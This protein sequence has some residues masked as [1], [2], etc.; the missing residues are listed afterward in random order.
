M[1][2][3]RLANSNETPTRE[4]TRGDRGVGIVESH[5]GR[6]LEVGSTYWGDGD[7]AFHAV[8]LRDDGTHELVGYCSTYCPG[9][10]GICEAAVDAPEAALE[11]YL[12]A[13]RRQGE[14]S[15]LTID[16]A[17]GDA[18]WHTAR[19]GALVRVVAGRKVPVGLE[20]RV[21]WT[22]ES[23]FG[24][25]V[26]IS[27][28]DGAEGVFTAHANIEVLEQPTLGLDPCGRA[29]ELPNPYLPGSNRPEPAAPTEIPV[30]AD[31]RPHFAR[32]RLAMLR[33]GEE[34]IRYWGWA[35]VP[36]PSETHGRPEQFFALHLQGQSNW[37]V[38]RAQARAFRAHDAETLLAWLTR[39]SALPEPDYLPAPIPAFADPRRDTG[40][41]FLV[42][43]SHQ[44]LAAP[45]GV[46][47]D[48]PAV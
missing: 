47:L 10:H 39:R 3:I 9:Q 35:V 18:E 41:R 12:E 44:A 43:A 16:S 21:F 27:P 22:G 29:Y 32:T 38:V 13:K 1:P 8:V 14:A 17:R 40:A 25:R 45:A 15:G 20:G 31:L 4:I 42:E 30:P 23:Q 5:V 28:L 2:V 48:L 37:G 33:A 26:G 24:T 34:P 19:K 36:Y 6:V 46:S 7:S 11:A